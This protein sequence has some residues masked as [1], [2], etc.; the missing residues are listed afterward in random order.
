[1]TSSKRMLG[2][3]AAVSLNKLPDGCHAD[4][5]NLYLLVRGQSRSWI[6]R[7]VGLEGKRKNMGL[8]PLH[9]VS[10]AEARKQATILREQL[11]HPTKPTDPM[12]DRQ[13][14]YQEAR[15]AHH[16]QMTFKACAT[17]YMSAHKGEWSNAKHSS[18]WQSTLSSYAYPVF[19][20]LQVGSVDEALILKVLTPIWNTKTETAK[21]LRGRIEAVLDWATFNKYRHGENPARWRGHLEHSLAKPSKVAK[22]EHHPALPYREIST[23][24]QEL[25][26]RDGIGPQAVEFLILTAA[27]SGEV[28]G[29]K[30]SELDLDQKIWVIPSAR[31]KA[32]RE[33]RVALSQAAIVLLSKRPRL[34]GC[35]FIFPGTKLHTPMSDMTMTAVLKRMERSD[36][37]VHGFR[38]TFRDWAAEATN[39]PNEVAEMALAHAVGNKVEAAYRRGDMLGKRFDMMNAWAEHCFESGKQ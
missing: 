20:D 28:R 36:I 1:M 9:S 11:K 38:S 21:R 35:E 13:Q 26:K 18:Q 12:S 10:L 3:L 6:F 2:R 24:M 32:E 33:H 30:W 8:G 34:E 29:A 14:R 4:G 25:R 22:V 39:Y 37:T 17:A 23:F 5:G 31:M 16:R 27:R 15:S 7:Y 19:G